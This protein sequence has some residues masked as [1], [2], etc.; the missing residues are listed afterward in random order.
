MAESKNAFTEIASDPNFLM[1]LAGAVIWFFGYYAGFL[2]P[3]FLSTGFVLV[4]FYATLTS[5]KRPIVLAWPGILLGGLLQII[6][7]YL[8]FILI[9]D[10]LSPVFI[11]TGGVI[12]MYFAIPLALQRGELP[13]IKQL[14]KLLESKKEEEVIKDIE[15]EEP[16]TGEDKVSENESSSN[17][18]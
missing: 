11:V 3:L 13:V 8:K 9:L 5:L 10:Q 16:L 14:Q 2:N 18:D 7:Y 1:I 15:T 12:I 4:C 17:N 6:G